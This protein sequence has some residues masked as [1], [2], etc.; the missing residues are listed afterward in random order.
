MAG[1]RFL[2]VAWALDVKHPRFLALYKR[3]TPVLSVK[4]CVK[5]ASYTRENTVSAVLPFPASCVGSK[6][7]GTISL[8]FYED[9]ADLNAMPMEL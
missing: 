6:R 3:R 8:S 9:V 2:C 1:N 7:R 4:I 5:S